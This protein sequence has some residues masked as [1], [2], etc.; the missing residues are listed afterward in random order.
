[1]L[2]DLSFGLNCAPRCFEG[3]LP[4]DAI[5]QYLENYSCFSWTLLMLYPVNSEVTGRN[6]SFVLL[7]RRYGR[8]AKLRDEK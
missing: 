5:L 7:I 4:F 1:M 8:N 3:K 6:Y 2:M